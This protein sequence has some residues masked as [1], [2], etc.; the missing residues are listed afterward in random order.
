MMETQSYRH[1]C[2]IALKN[3]SEYIVLVKSVFE[4]LDY[5]ILGHIYGHICSFL[6]D[7]LLLSKFSLVGERL[8][9]YN[10]P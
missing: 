10:L 3:N 5:F 9:P 1:L 6:S 7:L 4:S 8:G 2:L